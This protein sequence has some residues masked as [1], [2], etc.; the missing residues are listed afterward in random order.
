MIKKSNGKTSIVS[1]TSVP[2]LD[3]LKTEGTREKAKSARQPPTVD[4][5][6]QRGKAEQTIQLLASPKAGTDRQKKDKSTKAPSK[7]IKLTRLN[8]EKAVGRVDN[9]KKEK[10]SGQPASEKPD[11]KSPLKSLFSK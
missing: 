7:G 2:R 3:M 5:P 1:N 4:T 6:K 9:N 11:G 10:P 8:S